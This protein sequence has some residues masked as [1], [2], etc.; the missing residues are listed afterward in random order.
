MTGHEDCLTMGP[1]S[2][3]AG[4]FA[5]A[6]FDPRLGSDFFVRDFYKT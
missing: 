3:P 6:T 2:S 5:R 4:G 1:K